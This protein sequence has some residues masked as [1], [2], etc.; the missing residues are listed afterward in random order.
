MTP[1]RQIV[2]ETER[3]LI[4]RALRKCKYNVCHAARE[5]DVHRNTLSRKMQV[6]GIRR[7]GR[8][9]THAGQMA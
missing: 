7:P 9:M 8:P 6:L 1:L 5:L 2:A 3:A 4:L